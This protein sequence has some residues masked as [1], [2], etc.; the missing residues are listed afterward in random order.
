[1]PLNKKPNQY[2]IELLVLDK[3]TWNHLIVCKQVNSG[4]FKN[5]IYK[6]CIYYSYLIYM[7]K[8]DLALNNLLGLI[9]HKIQPTSKESLHYSM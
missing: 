8:E 2:W 3:N 6:I 4:S 1:M 5:V 7:Y 9:C